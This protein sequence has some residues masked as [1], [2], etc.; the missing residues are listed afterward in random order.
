[1]RK[2]IKTN[3]GEM[4]ENIVVIT[5]R[6]F[7]TLSILI[8]SSVLAKFGGTGDLVESLFG[9]QV[10]ICDLDKEWTSDARCEKIILS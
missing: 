7:C 2:S 6:L 5:L 9:G 4:R 8:C 10:S 1:M 3:S